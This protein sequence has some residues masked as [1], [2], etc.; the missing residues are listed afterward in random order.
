MQQNHYKGVGQMVRT[1]MIKILTGIVWLSGL[2]VA[3]SDSVY[4][5]W[6][7]VLGLVLF[8]GVSILMGKR[9][10]S[11]SKN[12]GA[13]I[14]ADFIKSKEF[15]ACAKAKQINRRSHTRYAISA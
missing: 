2:I 3:G 9:L 7:N 14:H 15:D 4:M 5:P 1:Q 11:A 10:H 6:V 8:S 13:L 12:S